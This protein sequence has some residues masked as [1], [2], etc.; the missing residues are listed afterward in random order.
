M[1][2]AVEIIQDNNQREII[3]TNIFKIISRNKI[4][5]KGDERFKK[6]IRENLI[7]LYKEQKWKS[8]NLYYHKI[9][10]EQIL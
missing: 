3:F 9:F 10:G 5:I 2:L 1:L 8:A 4:L 6:I 7:F